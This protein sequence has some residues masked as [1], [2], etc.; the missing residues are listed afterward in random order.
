[1]FELFVLAVVVL[2]PSLGF[3]AGMWMSGGRLAWAVFGSGLAG[4]GLG[5]FLGSAAGA[6][7]TAVGSGEA[8]WRGGAL[9]TG[10]GVV[11]GCGLAAAWSIGRRRAERKGAEGG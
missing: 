8:F 2:L 6:M 1:M 5:A 3:L 7:A 4:F 9:G 11:V 10:V